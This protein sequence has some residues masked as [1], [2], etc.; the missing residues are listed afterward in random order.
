M[1]KCGGGGG[2]IIVACGDTHVCNGPL[3]VSEETAG[4]IIMTDDRGNRFTWNVDTLLRGVRSAVTMSN[5]K[6]YNTLIIIVLYNIQV[7]QDSVNNMFDIFL[8]S[9]NFC[10]ILYIYDTYI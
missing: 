8:V 2:G 9:S 3:C 7:A 6:M 10:T 5:I 4:T 1:V